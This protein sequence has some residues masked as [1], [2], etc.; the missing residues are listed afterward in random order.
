M[1]PDSFAGKVWLLVIDKLFIG[2][3][4]G[5][6]FLVFYLW[7]NAR[8][9]RLTE[10]RHQQQLD[11]EKARLASEI[12]PSIAD[13]SFESDHRANLL[14][15]LTESRAISAGTTAR[16]AA[17]LLDSN[18]TERAFVQSVEPALL[19]DMKPFLREAGNVVFSWKRGNTNA[20]ICDGRSWGDD[21]PTE[22]DEARQALSRWRAAF[23]AL[24]RVE[25]GPALEA[26]NSEEFLGENLYVLAHVVHAG[27]S[28][29]ANSFTAARSFGV[30]LIGHLQL[31][32]YE[33]RN[34]GSI[35]FIANAIS[36]GDLQSPE[37]FRF[38]KQIVHVLQDSNEIFSGSLRGDIAIP[39]AKILTTERTISDPYLRS[40]Y[41]GIRWRAGEALWRMSDCSQSA[42]GI[43]ERHVSE[44]VDLVLSTDGQRELERL[45]QK[46]ESGELIR[47]SV[48]LLGTMEGK[49]SVQLFRRVAG[50][51]EKKAAHFPFLK[52]S[53]ESFLQ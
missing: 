43:L 21:R 45:S 17:I 29:R 36:I 5:V 14:S 26:L 24:V 31:V 39:L 12:L 1:D 19:Q 41:Y 35:D 46:Y 2:A 23:D 44:F 4:I 8:E 9:Q 52:E 7:S 22:T 16:L 33:P 30:R 53:A 50:I 42:K 20:S 13:S 37:D 11:L 49:P 47:R 10:Q 27:S 40:D 28:A 6:A 32:A 51:S 34:S 25:D 48:D 3:L 18:V 15:I 38:A